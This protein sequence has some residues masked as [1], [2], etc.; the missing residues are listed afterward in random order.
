MGD[1][2]CGDANSVAAHYILHCHLA[3]GRLLDVGA[4]LVVDDTLAHN[5]LALP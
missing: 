1:I 2:A 5:R 4:A 3:I